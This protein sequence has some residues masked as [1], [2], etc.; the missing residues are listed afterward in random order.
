MLKDGGKNY[1]RFDS[2]KNLAKELKF[3]QTTTK[4][5]NNPNR[6]VPRHILA[7]AILV[8]ERRVDPQNAKDTIKIVQN[9]VKN[10]KNYELNIIYKEADKS[11][12]H[13]H[14]W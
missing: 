2:V 9:F 1:E 10:K 13:F 4:H 7:E 14:Y 3:T 11:I 12:L 8:G 6:F 5:M